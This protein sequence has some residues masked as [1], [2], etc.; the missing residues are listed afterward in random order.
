[1]I[2]A[3]VW[4]YLD[5]W[6]L[7]HFIVII[8]SLLFIISGCIVIPKLKKRTQTI[9]FWILALSSSLVTIWRFVFLFD[10]YE[11]DVIFKL[12]LQ[13][14][15]FNFLILPLAC[16]K[17]FKLIRHYLL[18]FQLVGALL[19]YFFYDQYLAATSLLELESL[20]YWYYHLIP[21]ALPIFMIAAK[22][23]KTEKK[24]VFPTFICMISY[25]YLVTVGNSH[26][27][28]YRGYSI[29][30]TYSSMFFTNEN[31]ILEALYDFLPVPMLYLAPIYLYLLLTWYVVCYLFKNYPKS[32][33]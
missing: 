16:I 6:G 10:D 32:E 23:F 22:R 15:N 1:M 12:T 20:T 26:L 24:Y 29:Q 8:F 31:S 4:P 28:T 14:C 30:N 21:I 18:F 3:L 7:A 2:N 5:K 13:I 33:W 11:I 27:M 25:F 9:I 17:R 19:M